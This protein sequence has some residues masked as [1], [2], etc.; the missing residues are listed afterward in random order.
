MENGIAHVT[1]CVAFK[2][3]GYLN[4]SSFQL[5]YIWLARL[6]YNRGSHPIKS[7][8]IVASFYS[9]TS[10]IL[11]SME[12]ADLSKQVNITLTYYCMKLEVVK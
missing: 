10:L 7:S 4:L 8:Y 2:G 3:C 11:T 12:A 1:V 6:I 9:E 5:C